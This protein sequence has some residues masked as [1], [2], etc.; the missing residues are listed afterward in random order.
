M[1]P[2]EKKLLILFAVAAFVVVN[3]VGL[4][5]YRQKSEA[6]T[7]DMLKAQGVLDRFELFEASRQQRLDE[8]DWLKR[9]LPEPAESQNVQTALYA[10]S[11]S[12]ARSSGLEIR[13]EDLLPSEAPPGGYFHRAKVR[14]KV[15][16]TEESLYRWLDKINQPNQLRT[17]TRLVLSPNQEDDTLIDCT[18]TL[19]QWF[20]PPNPAVEPPP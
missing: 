13:T 20:V 19:E 3:A 4:S 5:F 9:N 11:T 10:A 17:A 8:M 2:R 6:L 14:L 18:A 15:T 16:G 12:A 7:A 1:S